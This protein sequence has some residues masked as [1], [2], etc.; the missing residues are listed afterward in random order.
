MEILSGKFKLN[1]SKKGEMIRLAPGI[2]VE[3]LVEENHLFQGQ[4]NGDLVIKFKVPYSNG[5]IRLDNSGDWNDFVVRAEKYSISGSGI[6]IIG[7]TDRHIFLN[8]RIRK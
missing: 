4:Y 6:E 5:I 3:F 7:T 8:Y 2:V 1:F